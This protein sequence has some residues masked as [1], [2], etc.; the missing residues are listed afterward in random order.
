MSL[1]ATPPVAHTVDVTVLVTETVLVAMIV[2]VSNRR[3]TMSVVTSM[4]DGSAVI[5]VVGVVIVTVSFAVTKFVPVVKV[6]VTCFGAVE[7]MVVDVDRVW[8]C[9]QVEQNGVA[10]AY[11]LRTPTTADTGAHVPMN[12]ARG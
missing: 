3:V 10:G 5:V 8:T 9:N 1:L 4:T 2:E 11:K 12:I 6:V 7:V